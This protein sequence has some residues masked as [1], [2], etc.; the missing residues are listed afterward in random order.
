MEPSAAQSLFNPRKEPLKQF[1][2]GS[3]VGHVALVAL[4]VLVSSVWGTKL[5]D[6]DQKPIK[7]SLVRRGKPREENMLPRK[8]ELPPPPQEVAA[9]P[10][11]AQPTP[12]APVPSTA[13]PVAIPGVKPVEK[14]APAQQA[15]KGEKTGEDRRKKLF[16]AFDKLAKK[17]APDEELEGAEDGDEEGDSATAEGERYLAMVKTQVQRNFDVSDTIPENE[18]R[19][20]KAQVLVKIGKR[21]ELLDAS[22]VRG[23]RNGLFDNAVLAAARNA[24]PFSPPPEHLRESLY[25][26]GV[27]LMFTP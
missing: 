2:I 27:V 7:A 17:S 23:S 20:L 4:G 19:Q 16:G 24:S 26:E 8:E 5:I 1:I 14:P 11:P 13:V 12:P 10:P 15:V 22:I 21:G 3:L 9:A 6:L 18:R 25:R